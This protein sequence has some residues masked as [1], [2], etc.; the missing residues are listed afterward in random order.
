[1]ELTAAQNTELERL[2]DIKNKFFSIVSHDLRSPLSTLQTLLAV[3]RAGDIGEKE[4]GELLVKLEDTILTTGTFLD[5]L[6]EWSKNQLEGMQINPVNFDVAES[7]KANISLFETKIEMKKLKVSSLVPA[8]VKVFADKDMI[9]LV[10]RNL[11]SNSIKF[12]NTGNEIIFSA[13]MKDNRT[14]VSIRDTGPGIS[15]EES[16][17]L[18][19]LEH[20]LSTGTHGEKGNHLGLILC[21]D[22]ITLN[23]GKI[24]FETEL[25]AGTTFWFELP[26]EK[27]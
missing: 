15:K 16:E 27:V 3:Y 8:H 22:M 17:K 5:N 20:T 12:C 13:E 4:L 23:Q 6:L 7:I 21:K 2:N 10:I 24:G 26:G 19:S 18:F 25:G 9:N 11:L 1:M 14:V